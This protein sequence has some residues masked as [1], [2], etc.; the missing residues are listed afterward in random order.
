M[1]LPTTF[2]ALRAAAALCACLLAA[3][4]VLAQAMPPADGPDAGP[5]FEQPDAR[6]GAPFW[7]FG[8]GMHA[9]PPF[10]RDLDLSEEQ[11]DRVSAI[12]H[13]QA[14][15]RRALD[16][17][18]RKAFQA[19]RDL[20]RATQLDEA[21]ASTSAQALGQAIADQELLRLQTGAQI[22]AVLT[23]AQRAQLDAPRGEG[24]KGRGAKASARAKQRE[25]G[26]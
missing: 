12:L 17:A 11:Q 14:P 1:T 19:L 9:G 6:A 22:K 24:R 23:P 8:E 7:A 21:R 10:L 16:K 3:P 26:Q 5:G 20:A 4:A 13:A 25:A 2:T 15:K 18:E